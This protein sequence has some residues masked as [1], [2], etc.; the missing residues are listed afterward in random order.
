MTF[1][2]RSSPAPGDDTRLGQKIVRVGKDQNKTSAGVGQRAKWI[3]EASP[4]HFASGF[5]APS[6]AFGVQ[7]WAR[8]F[9]GAAGRGGDSLTAEEL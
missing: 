8:N 2:N 9:M 1:E 7:N 3:G 4:L 5:D 6:P